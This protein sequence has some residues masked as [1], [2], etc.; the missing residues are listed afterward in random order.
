MHNTSSISNSKIF[1][2]EDEEAKQMT[3]HC[4]SRVLINPVDQAVLLVLLGVNSL[5]D[6]AA[7]LVSQGVNSLGGSGCTVSVTGCKFTQ[8]IR[9]HC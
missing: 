5:S 3:L 6:Q 1:E 4:R 2:R 9:L 7:L 8:W